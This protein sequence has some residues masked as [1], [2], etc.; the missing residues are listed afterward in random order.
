MKKAILLAGIL[1]ALVFTSCKK[2]KDDNG[3]DNNGGGGDNPT[4]KLI[5]KMTKVENGITTVYNF[6]YDNAKKL[7]GFASADNKESTTF[8]YDAAGNLIKVESI[9]QEFKNVYNYTYANGVPVSGTFKSWQKSAGEPDE[10]VEDDELTYTVANNQVTKL[11]LHMKQADE[12]L[13][14]D[15][16]YTN[17]NLSKVETVQGSAFSYKATFTFGTKK[18]PFPQVSKY[19]LDQAGFSLFFSSKN[20]LIT[21]VLDFPGTQLDET[22][23]LTYTYDANGYPLTSNDGAVKLTYEYQ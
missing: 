20:E 6:T 3:G 19:V 21:T 7:T 11:K 2:D 14:M 23:T 16:S 9:E 13:D 17:G 12:D 5:K 22:T 8:S 15:F 1:S 18:A 10:L 4:T